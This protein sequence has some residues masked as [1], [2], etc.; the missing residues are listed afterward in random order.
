[1]P[2][3]SNSDI[4]SI[5]SAIVS[6]VSLLFTIYF[7]TKASTAA[8]GASKLSTGQ[9][10]TSL[11]SA[12]SVTRSSVRD[13]GVKLAEIT[14]GKRPDQFTAEE[15]RR[16][17]SY[18]GPF[19]EALED[20]LNAYEDACAKYVDDKIDKERFKKS[21]IREI[22]NLCEAKPDNPVH[23]LLNPADSC[24]FKC[25]WKVYREWHHHE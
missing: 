14:N 18:Q 20:N 1:M 12:I 11:R 19:N 5:G 2:T 16:L 22:Q 25:V 4:I 6:F 3:L 10:E 7:S 21:Y 24:K 17:K 8:S 23:Q 9:A 15:T 13:I